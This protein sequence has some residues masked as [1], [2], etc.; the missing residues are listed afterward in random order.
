[1]RKFLG[2]RGVKAEDKFDKV[3]ERARIKEKKKEEKRKQKEENRRLKAEKKT[4][5]GEDDEE[6]SG[7]ESE[8]DLSWLPDPDK[9]YSEKPESYSN[10]EDEGEKVEIKDKKR[11]LTVIKSVIP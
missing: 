3:S 7:E 1:M 8:P 11:S 2:R 5:E 4:G 6:V 10:S 9:I